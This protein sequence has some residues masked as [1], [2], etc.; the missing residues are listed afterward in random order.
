[1]ALQENCQNL[2]AK[3]KSARTAYLHKEHLSIYLAK[4]S[5]VSEQAQDAF[6]SQIFPLTFYL[7]FNWMCARIIA[8]HRLRAQIGSG[9]DL[10]VCHPEL[11]VFVI[12]SFSVFIESR[13]VELIIDQKRSL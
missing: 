12:L 8:Y 1:M 4:L 7:C 5:E 3:P 10:T 9:S 6:F 13:Y 2:S 11:L